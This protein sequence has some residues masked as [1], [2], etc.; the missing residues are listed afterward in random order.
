MVGAR[1]T[2]SL[3]PGF[4]MSVMDSVYYKD[5]IV[6][7]VDAK[8]VVSTDCIVKVSSH[9]PAF[10]IQDVDAH[11]ATVKSLDFVAPFTLEC[12]GTLIRAFLTHFDTFFSPD[13]DRPI[14]P[15]EQVDIKPVDQDHTSDI[16]VSD[17]NE[18]GRQISFTTGPRGTITHWKQVVFLL[19]EPVS[20]RP[21][22]L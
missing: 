9:D 3:M 5:G 2:K 21:G 7:A 16:K 14:K 8:E 19:Q 18:S 1:V 6:E 11:R 20:V 17:A 22:T 10:L 13:S 15:D 12:T 4:D